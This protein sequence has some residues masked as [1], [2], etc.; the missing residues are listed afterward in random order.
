MANSLDLDTQG[1]IADYIIG[2]CLIHRNQDYATV[3]H[4]TITAL[5]EKRHSFFESI[6]KYWY[7]VF[8]QLKYLNSC[9][10]FLM[11][12]THLHMEHR[13]IISLKISYHNKNPNEIVLNA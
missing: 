8:Q 2:Y 10:K 11:T 12:L 7:L 4:Q 5:R 3:N 9:S 13:H 6:D 1:L